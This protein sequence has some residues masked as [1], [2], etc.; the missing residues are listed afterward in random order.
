MRLCLRR[1]DIA[2]VC[3]KDQIVVLLIG[4]DDDGGHLVAN[5]IVSSFYSECDDDSFTLEYDIH[6]IKPE[7]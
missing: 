7:R 5:R 3:G 1:G 6:E 2:S 4:A